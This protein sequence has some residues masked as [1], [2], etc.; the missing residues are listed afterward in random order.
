MSKRKI[1]EQALIEFT[2]AS[3]RDNK[4]VTSRI[5]P[6][7]ESPYSDGVP[8]NLLSETSRILITIKVSR[9]TLEI[10]LIPNRKDKNGLFTTAAT[11]AWP[12]ELRQPKTGKSVSYEVVG[13]MYV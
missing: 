9:K 12:R 13:V 7:E 4:K 10:V 11:N 2:S 3:E 8:S 6:L 1:N 5:K